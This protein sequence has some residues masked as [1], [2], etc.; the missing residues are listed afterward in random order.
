MACETFRCLARR[1]KHLQPDGVGAI[2]VRKVA[3]QRVTAIGPPAV[4]AGTLAL[5]ARR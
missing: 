1:G 4:V 2:P 5:W 3:E